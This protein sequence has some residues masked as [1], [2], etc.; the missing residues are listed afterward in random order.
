MIVES[1][2]SITINKLR[3]LIL[4]NPVIAMDLVHYA[5]T[6]SKKQQMLDML[7]QLPFT[8]HLLHIVSQL[9]PVASIPSTFY[10][11]FIDRSV[12]GILSMKEEAANV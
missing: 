10:V 9:T 6:S 12:K 1:N 3:P 4:N 7:L 5:L 8:L 2:A 11:G